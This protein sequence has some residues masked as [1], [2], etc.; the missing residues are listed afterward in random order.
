M[1]MVRSQKLGLA[2][3]GFAVLMLI[4]L[5]SDLVIVLSA[6]FAILFGCLAAKE[7]SR[8]WLAVP[9]V[10]TILIGVMMWAAFTA[11]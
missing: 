10:V 3:A 11:S 9:S 2:S 1:R 8:W 6:W 7:G 4:G 5:R